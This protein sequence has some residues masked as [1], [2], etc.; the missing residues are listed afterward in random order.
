MDQNVSNFLLY[1]HILISQKINFVTEVRFSQKRSHICLL[2]YSELL[3]HHWQKQ[4]MFQTVFTAL[5][6]Y[7]MYYPVL[8]HFKEHSLS[9]MDLLSVCNLVNYFGKSQNIEDIEISLILV[10]KGTRKYQ[11]HQVLTCLK[12][13]HCFKI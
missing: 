4:L 12:L 2:Q 7:S 8:L 6:M 10:Q 13:E 5:C 1:T 3:K 9:A 11:G